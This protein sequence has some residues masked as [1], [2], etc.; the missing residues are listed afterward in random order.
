MKPMDS[1]FTGRSG[2]QDDEM[3]WVAQVPGDTQ[4]AGLL[5]DEQEKS[6]IA[7]HNR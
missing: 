4:L 5:L 1:D 6:R 3:L 7:L 2:L